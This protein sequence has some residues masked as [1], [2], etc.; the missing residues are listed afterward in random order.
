MLSPWAGHALGVPV[1]SELAGVEALSGT[2]LP[3][4]VFAH[5]TDEP[6]VVFRRAS[7]E[8]ISVGIAFIYDMGVR[9]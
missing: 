5:R 6:N 3:A 1:N 7:G 4:R 2:C 9:Q 8:Q